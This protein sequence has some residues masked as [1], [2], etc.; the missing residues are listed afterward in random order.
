M[1]TENILQTHG[2]TKDFHGF[3]AVKAVDLAI[4]RHSIHAL[5]GPNGAG[6]TTCF[7]LL[8]KFL[9][10]SSG[11][12]V[13]KGIDITHYK[14]DQV[15]RLGLVR[16]FQISA[17]FPHLSV[18]ENVRIA[19]QRARG[20]SF[21]F[22]RSDKVLEQLVPRA[23]ELLDAV[24]LAELAETPAV[25]LSYGRKRALEIATTLALD[26]E[27]MLLDEPTSGMGHEDVG[28][29]AALIKKI[30]ANRTIIM[31]EHN[32]SVVADLCDTITVLARGEIL[33]EGDYAAV[34][35]NPEVVEAYL[36]TA[37]A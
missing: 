2:L 6:K 35:T 29:I 24:G 36:G 13:Y 4:R 20:S 17:V 11:T 28:R 3:V 8:T 22:W 12:I 31:V 25:E 33:A 26:P 23:L 15:T 21:D 9:Q 34:S 18:L 10:A 32:L 27:T 7:N 5:I 37:H 14:P 1:T 30:S 16:S 19:L